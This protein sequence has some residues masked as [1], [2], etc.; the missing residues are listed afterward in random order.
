MAIEVKLDTARLDAIAS[1]LNKNAEQICIGFA[2]AVVTAARP[3]EPVDTGALAASMTVVTRNFNGQEAAKAAA[4]GKNKDV[5][6]ADDIPTP[7]DPTVFAHVGPCVI[8]GAIQEFGG[9]VKATNAPFLV[10]QTKDGN[11]VRTKEVYIPAHPYLTPAT[12][13]LRQ[14]FNSGV[15]WRQLVT[16]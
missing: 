15:E 6:F 3:F 4:T 5:K 7:S 11:W 10:F 8:Y 9:V 1:S 12:E 13:T 16:G 2:F 14:R